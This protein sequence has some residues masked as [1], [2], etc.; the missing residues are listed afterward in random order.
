MALETLL[1]RA[2]NREDRE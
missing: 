1:E 2:C